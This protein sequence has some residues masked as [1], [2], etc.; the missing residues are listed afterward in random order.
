M[1]N[2]LTIPSSLPPL[3][4]A[5]QSDARGAASVTEQAGSKP[6]GRLS[7]L[8]FFKKVLSFTQQTRSTSDADQVMFAVTRHLCDLFEC[9]WFV[10]YAVSNDRA[11]LVPRYT[12]G[13][14]T[15]KEL[16]VPIAD[17]NA[18]GYVAVHRRLLCIRDAYDNVEL[19]THAPALRFARAA[20]VRAGQRSRQLLVAPLLDASDNTLLG[21]LQLVNHRS[22]RPFRSIAAEGLK[23]LCDALAVALRQRLKPPPAAPS[24]YDFLVTNAVL[25]AAEF[26]RASRA[27]NAVGGDFERILLEEHHVK[28]A[29]LGATLAQFYGVAYEP[30]KAER[31]KPGAVL[32]NIKREFVE[33]N[34]WLLI[35]HDAEQLV[36][37]ATD[38][39]QVKHSRMV[40][41]IF[42]KARLVF[43][44]TTNVEFTLTVDQFFGSLGET[45]SVGDL[46]SG[47]N[48]QAEEARQAAEEADASTS[49][50]EDNE[51]VQLVN[52]IILEAYRQ[53][54]SDIHIEPGRGNEKTLIRFRKDGALE[55]YIE[56]PASYRNALLARIKIMC[57]L[58]TS[59]HRKPQDGKI[60]F[61]KEGQID[62]ELRVLTIP[63]TGG[64]EDVVMRIL[65]AGA[66]TPLEQLDVLPHNL[67]RL[68]QVISNPHGLFFVCGP[69]GSGKTTTLHS[70]L[71]ELNTPETKIW[72]AE[73]PVE[74][75]QKGMRQVQINR[76]AGLDFATVMRSLLRADPD[77][78]MIG[79]M[80]DKESVTIC[81]EASLTG[82]L[83]LATLHTNSAAESIV[84]L[85][86]MG[87]DPFTCGDAL[88]G[89]LAQRL[90]RRVCTHCRKATLATAAEMDLLVAEYCAEIRPVAACRE[91]AE[92]KRAQVLQTWTERR[93]DSAGRFTLYH[94]L[95]CDKCN[96]G[97]KG[98][99]GLHELMVNSDK[100]KRLL[101]E[102]A[103]VADLL[104]AAMEDGMLTLKMDGIEKVLAG[105]TDMKQVR[106]VCIH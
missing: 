72:T 57:N 15:T 106:A 51:L 18:A 48:E 63:A 13:P 95:G 70:V 86:D 105:A 21:V 96:N 27:A 5:E 65:A 2:H 89:V 56:I 74:I 28:L 75:T 58:D 80:R 36:I 55:P 19:A 78:I 6:D 16:T 47:M 91:D 8:N 97:Y 24:P 9:A 33:H 66:P 53:G 73:D 17:D 35:E 42:P 20:D 76:K 26:A 88:L 81:L 71:R 93:A 84:R 41:N 7:R 29:A 60:R 3:L 52:K 31:I 40:N 22:G 82:H 101:Q 83:V 12:N 23:E 85:L 62:I 102:R 92:A 32:K 59:E 67:Q 14:A 77:I 38:P 98:R 11:T 10:L 69:T 54:A 104:A 50:V 79:E 90:T 39:D 37:L 100:L 61:H 45:G 87:M 43:R 1:A 46:L 64:V 103:R 68:K 4:N 30:F 99:I 25:T 44:V 94:P 49:A 34:R